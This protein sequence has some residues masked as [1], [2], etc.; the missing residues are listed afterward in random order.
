MRQLQKEFRRDFNRSISRPS[1]KQ[2]YYV[3]FSGEDQ[4]RPITRTGR[5]YV[6]TAP[7]GYEFRVGQLRNLKTDL[8][9]F[10]PGAKVVKG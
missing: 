3:V 6:V 5:Q 9:T 1:K 10:Y 7:D 2:R 8:A 4:K